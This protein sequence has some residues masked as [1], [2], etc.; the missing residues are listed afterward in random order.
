MGYRKSNYNCFVKK[1]DNPNELIAYNTFSGSVGII[2]K[3]Q[4]ELY[5]TADLEF[6]Q[7][8]NSELFQTLV[9]GGFVVEENLNEIELMK[10]NSMRAR[11]ID[12]KI[13][14]T[15]NPYSGCNC[16]CIYCFESSRLD[17]GVLMS[18]SIQE[19]LIEHLNNS[20]VGK[21]SLHINWFGGE[22]LIGFSVI[23]NLSKQIIKMC[24]E[25]EIAYSSS[26]VTNGYLLNDEIV[27][28]MKEYRILNMQITI[29]GNKEIH[30]SR[31]ILKNGQGTF[32]VIM[33]NVIKY[34]KKGPS[35]QLRINSDKTNLKAYKDVVQI[36]EENGIFNDVKVNLGKVY[37]DDTN[38]YQP[39]KCFSDRE[40]YDEMFSFLKTKSTASIVLAQPAINGCAAVNVNN[41]VLD[42]DGSLYK[43]WNEVGCAEYSFGNIMDGIMMKD[44]ALNYTNYNTF[45]REECRKC[46]FVP[47]CMGGCMSMKKDVIDCCPEKYILEEKLNHIV[48]TMNN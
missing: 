43:C 17:K 44:V 5:D 47:I 45:D 39:E 1:Y 29:D 37:T 25:Q 27:E 26:I 33:S 10:F 13:S 40:F 14:L 21:K 22:P 24:D 42:A 3:D 19:Q 48:T 9:D 23:E 35:I 36:L 34:A 16:R 46:K 30:D 28:K 20:L 11:F 32:D 4:K 31:R 7:T 18:Q 8:Q 6:L 12:D 15:V 41:F 38:D 2:E